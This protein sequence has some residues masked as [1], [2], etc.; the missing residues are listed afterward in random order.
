MPMD[1]SLEDQ[2]Y[3]LQL[4]IY[5]GGGGELKTYLL[6]NLVPNT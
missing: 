2:N 3:I 4:H 5:G 6:I 1:R